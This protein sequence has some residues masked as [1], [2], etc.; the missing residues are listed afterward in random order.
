M[1][2][3]IDELNHL[4]ETVSRRRSS[5]V[6][7][8]L[9]LGVVV[10]NRNEVLLVRRKKQEKGIDGSILTWSFPGAKQRFNESRKECVIRGVLSETG[11]KIDPIREISF[12]FHPQFPVFIVYHFCRFASS[13]PI[14]EPSQDYEIAEV[15]WVKSKEIKKLITTDLDLKVAKILGLE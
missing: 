11:Y 9:N 5:E 12:R 7:D 14:R 1:R 2:A 3:K 6:E 15:R 10:N 4:L 13:K 8:F